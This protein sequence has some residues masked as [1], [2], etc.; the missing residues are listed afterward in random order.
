M[1]ELRDRTGYP[2]YLLEDV[3]QMHSRGKILHLCYHLLRGSVPLS[4]FRNITCP[5]TPP[6]IISKHIKTF[7]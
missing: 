1:E 6:Q 7:V 2:S 3:T 4:E 5:P